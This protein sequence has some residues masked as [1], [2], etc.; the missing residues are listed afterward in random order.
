MSHL[1]YSLMSIDPGL[2]GRDPNASTL[3]IIYYDLTAG[4]VETLG[5][6]HQGSWLHWKMET[7]YLGAYAKSKYFEGCVFSVQTVEKKI[8]KIISI[9]PGQNSFDGKLSIRSFQR[10]TFL[11]Q[12][13]ILDSNKIT[14]TSAQ[15]YTLPHRKTL[16][17]SVSTQ[18]WQTLRKSASFQT[19]KCKTNKDSK[20][21]AN[22]IILTLT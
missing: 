21:P 11:L 13:L 7:I 1:K 22:R 2:S 6:E 14:K 12:H 5:L 15:E 4:N 18:P 19:R 17:T 8:K 9:Y 3:P 20:P 10:I 16:Q